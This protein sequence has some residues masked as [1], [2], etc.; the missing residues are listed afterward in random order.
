MRIK[1]EE[2]IAQ[3]R[4][5]IL[6]Q[7]KELLKENGIE[8]LSIRKL[9]QRIEQTPG[10]IYHYFVDK[11]ALLL[12]IVEE[13]YQDI[14]RIIQISMAKASGVEEQL[15]TVCRAYIEAMRQQE[16]VYKII[17]QSSHPQLLAKTA[18]M[19]SG[20]SERRQSIQQLCQCLSIGIVQ[21]IFQCDDVE[22]RAQCIWSSVYGLLQRL[23]VEQVDQEQQERLIAE[24]IKMI[25]QSLRVEK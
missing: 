18:I 7:A 3:R 8:Q 6:S 23:I 14:L 25:M 20:I 9:A 15:S 13:G 22:L 1:D 11:D 12:A 21:G 16:D 19:T 17:M 4:E 2:V 10:I 24:L 5:Y